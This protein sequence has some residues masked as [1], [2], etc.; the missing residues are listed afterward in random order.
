[1]ERA[2]GRRLGSI[3]AAPGANSG[4]SALEQ[5]PR[6]QCSEVVPVAVL[7][8]G[9][10]TFGNLAYLDLSVSLIQMI[11]TAIPVCVFLLGHVAGVEQLT[12]PTFLSVRWPRVQDWGEVYHRCECRFC[13]N[14]ILHF[15]G[16][17]SS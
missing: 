12:T 8:A 11:K 6:S 1:M 2:W 16:P 17:V 5:R 7:L 15:L 10:L 9:S 13:V 3:T 4:A 14:L